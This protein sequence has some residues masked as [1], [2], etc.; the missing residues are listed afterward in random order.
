MKSLSLQEK[1]LPQPPSFSKKKHYEIHDTLG[2]GSFGKVMVSA[3]IYTTA[4]RL[5]SLVCH[6][7]SSI[8]SHGKQRNT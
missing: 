5:S 7:F 6:S 8:R 1:M 2:T 3:S 4:D